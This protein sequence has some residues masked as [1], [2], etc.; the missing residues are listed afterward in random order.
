[1]QLDASNLEW[2]VNQ[3]AHFLSNQYIKALEHIPEEYNT[4]YSNYY[5]LLSIRTMAESA[6]LAWVGPGRS[7]T[8]SGDNRHLANGDDLSA[9][10]RSGIG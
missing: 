1:M 2:E 6:R 4:H 8:E 7:D 9:Q 10:E 3:L 5:H